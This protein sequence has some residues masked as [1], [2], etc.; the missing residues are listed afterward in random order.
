MIWRLVISFSVAALALQAATVSGTVNLAD[1]EAHR[2]AKDGSGVVVWLEPLNTSSAVLARDTS[3]KRMLQK[4]KTF[5][6]HVLAVEVGTTVDF[7]NDDPIFHNAFSNYNGQIFDVALYPPGS[8]RS[9]TFRRVGVV[10]VFCNIHS[11]MS[12]VIVVVNTSLF[13]VTGKDGSFEIEGV[14]K[15]DYRVSFYYERATDATLAGLS[16]EIPVRD[17]VQQLAATSI[18]ESGYL[19][20]PHLNKYGKPYGPTA[21]ALGYSSNQQ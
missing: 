10:R 18:S 20:I 14:P 1:N 15:G 16:K 7:P 4:N 12:A 11:T 9:V 13:A 3:R 2:D 17:D 6:P 21:D 19:P 5:L 8:S